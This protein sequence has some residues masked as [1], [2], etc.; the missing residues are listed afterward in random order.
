MKIFRKR[1]LLFFVLK[2]AIIVLDC[3]QQESDIKIH[4]QKKFG[5]LDVFTILTAYPS[6]LLT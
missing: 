2:Q 6:V 4:A 5:G 1:V 3:L